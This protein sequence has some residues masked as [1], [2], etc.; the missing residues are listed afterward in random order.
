M[1]LLMGGA[2]TGIPL[3]VWLLAFSMFLFFSLA[4]V[5]RQAELVD[6]LRAGKA[7]A[8]GR[9]Y[10]VE[11]LPILSMMGL[12]SG[13]VAVLVMALYLS[14][15]AVAQL[16]PFPPALWGLCAVLLYWVSRI[17]FVTHRGRMHDDPIVFA[18]RDRVSQVC[19]LLS[20]VFVLMGAAP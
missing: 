6:N 2:A 3:S 18:A 19:L 9:G 7:G 13:Y 14:S 16:Y 20:L 4:A 5:K 15:P 17:V 12:A 1:R 10:I 11:D 8:A